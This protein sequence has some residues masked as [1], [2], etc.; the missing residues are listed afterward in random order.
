MGFFPEEYRGVGRSRLPASSDSQ[1]VAIPKTVSGKLTIHVGA[2]DRAFIERIVRR[3]RRRRRG[4]SIGEAIVEVFRF[5]EQYH[6]EAGR[7]SGMD[8][9]GSD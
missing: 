4:I 1:D 8:A 2:D 6:S 7:R 3:L 9:G 5:Y